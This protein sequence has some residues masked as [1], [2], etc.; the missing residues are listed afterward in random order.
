M[1]PSS[2][3]STTLTAP[4]SPSSP[5]SQR[6][7]SSNQSATS[8]GSSAPL[9]NIP[10][11]GGG[12]GGG[13]GGHASGSRTPTTFA[14]IQG[15]DDGVVGGGW[16]QLAK[17][18]DKVPALEAFPRFH[19]ANITALLYYQVEIAHLQKLLKLQEKVD[20]RMPPTIM[21]ENMFY[22]FPSKMIESR[23]PQWVLIERLQKCV[24]RYSKNSLDF[25][26]LQEAVLY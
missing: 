22:S 17:L 8:G 16:P 6:S 4:S 20:R 3:G 14:R 13:N 12:H 23:T 18:M 9:L 26:L 25:Y 5:T 15:Q 11:H 21:E 2:V 10:H 24:H 7:G 19:D 1:A